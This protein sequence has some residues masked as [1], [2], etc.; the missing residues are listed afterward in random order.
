V[1]MR[2]PDIAG[3]RATFRW[4]G[5][6]H[7]V[8]VAVQPR[9]ETMLRR[10]PGG[11]L[12][13][14][15][16]FA[17]R[18]TQYLRRFKLAGYDLV[19]RA[20]VYVPLEIDIRICVARGHLRGD[21]LAAVAHVLSAQDHAVGPR[22]FFNH[23]AFAFGEPV[24]LSRLYAAVEAVPGVDSA[25]VTLF[26]RYWTVVGDALARGVIALAPFEIARLEND[27]NHAEDG[28]LRL[29]VVGGL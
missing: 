12:E 8:F 28:V 9:S 6:W 25:A 4:T 2:H 1:A 24:Y 21:V 26:K 14:E 13:L 20:A 29:T 16:G 27:P 3:A 11:G 19:V 10:L 18:I 17:Q 15:A 22:G 23:L 7:T 5:S